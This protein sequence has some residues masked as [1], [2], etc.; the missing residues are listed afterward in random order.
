MKLINIEDYHKYT[1][2]F[3]NLKHSIPVVYSVFENMYDGVLYV[4][5]DIKPRYAILFTLF[6]FHY[7]VGEVNETDIKDIEK[8][9]FNTYIESHR[10]SELVFQSDTAINDQI[11]RKVFKKYSDIED[12]RH[13]YKVDKDDLIEVYYDTDFSSKIERL[14]EKDELSKKPYVQYVFKEKD[15]IVSYA[16]AFMIGNNEAE[17]DVFTEQSH[18]RKGYALQVSLKLVLELIETNITPNWTTWPFRKESQALA[19]KIGFKNTHDILS[20]IWVKKD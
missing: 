16:K 2:L 14:Y 1:Y 18:Q 19:K 17:I 3:K 4:N 5:D 7:L 8:L 15:N 12:K 11:L 20:F 9:I 10:P 13:C 6:D